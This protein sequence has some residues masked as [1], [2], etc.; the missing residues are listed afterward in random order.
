MYWRLRRT[1][2][3]TMTCNHYSRKAELMHA[4]LISM[5]K[6]IIPARP[7]LEGQSLLQRLAA[8]SGD[9]PT[10]HAVIVGDI[11][12]LQQTAHSAGYRVILPEVRR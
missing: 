10:P 8:Y 3:N 11:A 9:D 6:T 4:E 1:R 5:T 12:A 2:P 7:G